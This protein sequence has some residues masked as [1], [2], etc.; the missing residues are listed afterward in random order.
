[1]GCSL[2][3]GSSGCRLELRTGN[4]VET[5]WQRQTA[6]AVLP[7]LLLLRRRLSLQPAAAAASAAVP[8][9]A[10][11][12]PYDAGCDAGWTRTGLLLSHYQL[13]RRPRGIATAWVCVSW[14]VQSST[15][16]A[17]P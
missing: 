13:V 11:S 17:G 8:A 12:C 6:H 10:C 16:V 2:G 4:G 9:A 5:L 14:I 1:M 3:A 15:P 7:R